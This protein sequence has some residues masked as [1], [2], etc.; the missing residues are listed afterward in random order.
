MP[1]NLLLNLTV[2]G[3][4]VYLLSGVILILHRFSYRYGL[5]PLVFFLGGLAAS[6]QFRFLGLVTLTVWGNELRLSAGSYILL[7]VL[8]LGL[9]I[10]YIFNG[11]TQARNTL[12]GLIVVTLFAAFAQILFSIYQTLPA[13][14]K[15]VGNT[16]SVPARIPLASA[17]TLVIDMFVIT[18]VYQTV[19]NL[20]KRSPSRL[21]GILALLLTLWSDALIFPTLAYWGSTDWTYQL[22]TNLIGKGVSA[23]ALAPIVYFYLGKISE[24]FSESSAVHPRR[25]LD[26]LSTHLQLEA[27]AQYQLGL[28][29]TISQIN[30]LILRLDQPKELLQK[31][32][33]LLAQGRDYAIIWIGLLEKDRPSPGSPQSLK[34]AA[35]AGP[36]TDRL[37]WLLELN[38]DS[39]NTGEKFARSAQ[40]DQ[41]VRSNRAAIFK[42]TPLSHPVWQESMKKAGLHACAAFPMRHENSLVGILG[43]YAVRSDTFNNPDEVLLLQE[44]ADDLA[45]ALVSLE[46]RQQQAFLS[47]AAETMR[48][49]L[50]ITDMHGN[51]TYANPATLDIFGYQSQ[52]VL[53]HRIFDLMPAEE[54]AKFDKEYLPVLFKQGQFT[55]E[56]SMP[57]QRGKT[58]V[59]IKAALVRNAQGKSTTVV[60]SVRDVMS[61][62]K[63]EQR[64]LTLNRNATELVQIHDLRTICEMILHASEELLDADAS[65][66]LLVNSDYGYITEI[67]NHGLPQAIEDQIRSDSSKPPAAFKAALE[68]V[69][70][71]EDI[72]N[73]P[74]YR[75]DLGFL[76]GNGLQAMMALP[77]FYQ[78]KSC[79]AL[80][81][82]YKQPHTFEG[83]EKQLGLS[84]C[85]NLAIAMQNAQLYEAEHRQRQLAEALAQATA[86]LNRSLD[87]DT[88]LDHILEQTMRVIPCRS[89]SLMLIDGT[90]VHIV[91]QLLRSPSG[92][93]ESVGGGQTIPLN[94]PTLMKMLESGEPLL[95]S[96]TVRN[97]T[98]RDYGLTTWIRSYASAPLFIHQ[99]VIGFLNV[100]SDQSGFFNSEILSSLK[101]FASNASAA[102][103]N[104]RLY[105][106]LQA[107]T[108]DLEDRIRER[109]VE[110]SSAKNRMET[111][112]ASVPDAVFVVDRNGLL[113]EA[114][115]AGVALLLQTEKSGIDLFSEDLMLR[116]NSKKV[117]EEITLLEVQERAY[118]AIAS[119]LPD[120]Q[121]DDSGD[122]SPGMVIV[123][124]DVTRFHEL[125]R[126][127]TQF[128]SDVSHELRT[129][130]TSLSL[131]LDLLTTEEDPERRHRFQAT[132]RR[133][134][135]RLTQ[136]IED[137]LTISRLESNRVSINILPIDVNQLVKDLALDRSPIAAQ[138]NIS[139]KCST[140]ADIPLTKA[141]TRML[142][143]VISNLLTNAINYTPPEGQVNLQTGC[144]ED[145]NGQWVFIAVE[146]TGVGILP[147]ELP[148]IFE[149]FYRGSASRQ[150][151]APGTGLGLAISK[152]ILDRMNGRITVQTEPG[153]GSTFTVWLQAVL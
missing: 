31:S 51:I 140:Q 131:Y 110:L 148:H 57:S 47:T 127:K 13:A 153:K 8:L 17:V 104:A 116:L 79:G 71:I 78:G 54:V 49:G 65:T 35:E 108:M 66:V 106:E 152:E 84:A 88:L 134:T 151:N 125:D 85:N 43:V 18:S 117:S 101:G 76:S 141:D 62:W 122:G 96:D 27:R 58:L 1:I 129:P 86:V 16:I 90:E 3:F 128:V 60:V 28:L 23:L 87:L 68:E 137:L 22:P 38:N 149:R 93:I 59:S 124:R 34:F 133:E 91:R 30:Q 11:T 7:P 94:T 70:Y 25:V 138:R 109:T 113:L 143:Q 61:R 73:D 98:W 36:L 55:T 118:Q 139:L 9:M 63:Y 75:D 95:I 21:A 144:Q 45:Y 123:F 97:T 67:F 69:I 112:L 19:S 80:A 99:E 147:E 132:L 126:M 33:E 24:S 53:N 56:V 102:L 41:V 40:T 46:A 107:R 20:R 39:H 135:N 114:N 26:I 103:Y 105:R 32:C 111:I 136:L 130:L 12:Y 142:T 37:K 14:Y 44:L 77:V 74:R 100:N 89:A 15:I 29:R 82:Y 83:S 72:R 2:F 150:T 4:I 50:V 6:L 119:S 48:D 5:L 145:E 120:Y 52:D 92:K 10:I 121:E 146:D 115:Q 81:I 42:E 64:L